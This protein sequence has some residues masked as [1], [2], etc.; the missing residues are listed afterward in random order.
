MRY[1]LALC[2]LFGVYSATAQTELIRHKSHSGT[3]KNF[4]T[5]RSGNFGLVE[6]RDE[7]K[8]DPNS[9][10]KLIRIAE[11]NLVRYLLFKTQNKA[12]TNTMCMNN[13]EV[14]ANI[15]FSTVT[16]GIRD[17]I[18]KLLIEELMALRK[19]EQ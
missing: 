17:N 2:L 7:L 5:N 10:Y 19:G 8:K 13:D 4:K 12:L 3:N 1:L 11:G 14:I 6:I 15:S 16:A 9:S 18:E